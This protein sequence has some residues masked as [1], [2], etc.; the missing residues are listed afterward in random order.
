M[1]TSLVSVIV[2]AG[3]AV[4]LVILLFWWLR[5]TRRRARAAQAADL[6][7]IRRYAA[8]HGLAI[9]N[10]ASKEAFV[11]NG[12]LEGIP[13]SLATSVLQMV[14]QQ[15]HMAQ[16][17]IET[18]LRTRGLPADLKLLVGRPVG[19]RTEVE[20]P[21]RRGVDRLPTGDGAF[22]GV[23]HSF[24]P[25]P[26]LLQRWVDPIGRQQMLGLEVLREVRLEDGELSI[27]MI[28]GVWFGHQDRS[29]WYHV[30]PLVK[31]P[32]TLDRAARLL[33]LLRGNIAQRASG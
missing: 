19:R 9:L 1:R 20:Q 31:D 30:R 26:E 32:D 12:T 23:F 27:S 17:P 21:I 15:G 11:A 28:P 16:G 18:T 14:S 33:A 8:S 13:V 3:A 2:V 4:G 5:R 6:R 25:D 7:H 24:A 29:N 10:G 22:D